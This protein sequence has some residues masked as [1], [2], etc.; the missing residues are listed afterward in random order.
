MGQLRIK[1]WDQFQHYKDRAPPW[2][3]LHT[4]VLDDYEFALLPDVQK[5]HLLLIWLF[6]SKHEGIVP[7]D[8]GF[9]QRKLGTTEKINLK[10]LISSGFLLCV[11]PL[12][13]GASDALAEC[14]QD[15]SDSLAFARVR[16]HSVSASASASVSPDARAREPEPPGLNPA[17]WHRWAAYRV[18]IRKPIKPAS[19]LAAQRKLAGFGADQPAVVEQ[20]IANGWQGLFPVGGTG[21]GQ[22]KL[23]A[24]D[25]VRQATGVDLRNLPPQ[26]PQLPGVGHG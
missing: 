18:E 10:A 6:A 25:R 11:D 26:P 23:S 24:V 13:R 7:D 21:A 9:L 5:A 20:S 14:Q 17:A 22:P 12:E 16:A 2:I 1:N 4:S 15:A 19:L 8:A 3:K